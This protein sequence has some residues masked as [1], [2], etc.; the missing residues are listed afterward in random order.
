MPVA[1][2]DGA[3]AEPTLGAIYQGTSNLLQDVILSKA[4]WAP[5]SPM[6]VAD[7]VLLIGVADARAHGCS[8]T[9]VR[10]QRSNWSSRGPPPVG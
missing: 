10:T 9:P 7:V 2:A 1:F 8:P 3:T 6:R 5:H 4:A